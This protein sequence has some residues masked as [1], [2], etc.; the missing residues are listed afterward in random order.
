MEKR[1][2]NLES[3]WDKPLQ[4]LLPLLQAIPAGL[5]T[6]EAERRLRLYGPNS[7]VQ[8]S[9]FAALWPGLQR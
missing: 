9:R 2:K 1:D 5:T 4:D 6:G 8:E 3:F 7:M